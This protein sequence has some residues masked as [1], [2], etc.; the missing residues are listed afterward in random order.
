MSPLQELLVV[1]NMRGRLLIPNING[2][3]PLLLEVFVASPRVPG[4]Q[5]M[6]LYTSLKLIT[7]TVN[8]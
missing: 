7:I 6:N 5:D 4:S 1:A 2:D 3:S 8:N